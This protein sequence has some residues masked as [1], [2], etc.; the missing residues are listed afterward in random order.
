MCTVH[1]CEIT[2]NEII[3]GAGTRQSP[4]L[5]LKMRAAFFNAIKCCVVM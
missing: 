1:D 3:L 4:T 2:F 5:D